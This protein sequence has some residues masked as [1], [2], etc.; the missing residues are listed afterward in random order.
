MGRALEAF[1]AIDCPEDQS[2]FRAV[3]VAFPNC[4]DDEGSARLKVAQ[5]RLRPESILRGKMIGLF[6]PKSEDEGL[7]NPDFRPLRSPVP[8]LAI[9]ML[10]END[11]PF[12]LRNPRLA[13]IYLMKFPLSGP[14]KLW[15]ALWR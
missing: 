13:P 6:E 11:A 14:L 8:L 9:R 5:N 3:I 10:V 4:G 2:H 15:R 7:V 1:E 12:V